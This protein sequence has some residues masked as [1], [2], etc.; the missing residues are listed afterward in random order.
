MRKI[1]KQNIDD[2]VNDCI[3]LAD[4]KGTVKEDLSNSFSGYLSMEYVENHLDICFRTLIWGYSNGSL[5]I[6]VKQKGKV[7]LDAEGKFSVA[8]YNM[9]AKKYTHGKWEDRVKKAA[10][11]YYYPKEADNF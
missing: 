8:A 5:Q 7:V 9:K 1:K 11:K 3:V 10:K 4:R 6:V 2:L